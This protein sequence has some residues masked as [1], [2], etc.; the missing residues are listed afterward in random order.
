LYAMVVIRNVDL[1]RN[2]ARSNGA[3]QARVGTVHVGSRVPCPLNCLQNVP[4]IS[5]ATH[6]RFSQVLHLM[7]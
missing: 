5:S 6:T 4:L 1:L 7:R 3:A 2:G